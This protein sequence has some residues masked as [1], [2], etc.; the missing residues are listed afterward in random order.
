[1]PPRSTSPS[2][3]EQ[4]LTKLLAR[5]SQEQL[6]EIAKN[7]QDLTAAKDNLGP[8]T[9]EELWWT[10]KE[11][12]GVELG[13]VAV[14][15]G[16][17]SQLDL[18]WEV[19]S[20]V[21]TRVLWVLSRGSGKTFLMA[22]TDECQ[23]E[24]YPGFEAFTIG[25]GKSQGERKYD[26]ILPYVIE[27]GVIGGKEFDHVARSILTKTE[28]LNGSKMEISL[29]GEPENANGP[30]VPRLHRDEIELMKE[31]TR[32]QA[33]NIPA[34][35]LSRDGRY[36]PAQIIDTSTMKYAGGYVDLQM[37]AYNEAKIKGVRPR[38][39]VRI[40]CI[41]EAAHEVACCRAA[42]DDARRARLA[43]LGRDPAEL[44]EC[45]EVISGVMPTEDAD[46]EPED[47]TLEKVCQ[48]RLFRSRGHK[49]YAD[50]ITLFY[51][52]EPETWDAEQEC[53]QPAREGAYIRSYSQLRH[54]VRG[55][56]PDPENGP[57][58][59]S[60]D[61][62]GS[63]A[64]SHGWYQGLVRDVRCA[65]FK[66]G[67]IKTLHA[68]SVVRFAE[69]YK[70]QIG[71]VELGQMVIDREREWMLRWPGWQVHERYCD[72]ANRS[73]ILNWRD[74]C[75]LVAFSRVQKDFKQEVKMVRSR[76]GGRRFYVDIREC[77][78][79]DK[80]IRA[81]HQENGHEVHDWSTHPTAE[82]RYFE[83][84]YQVH[85]RKVKRGA[86]ALDVDNQPSTAED[87]DQ[88]QAER[89]D[90]LAGRVVVVNDSRRPAPEVYDVGGA[91]DSPLTTERA[92]DRVLSDYGRPSRRD[93]GI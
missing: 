1:M 70:D 9:K 48:G 73:G 81:W 72:V 21:V 53:S 82:L 12:Y 55:Y 40:S 66:T 64:H 74:Q 47:R 8:Q 54:G 51:E 86:R 25:P 59:T 2:L 89:H 39:E 92:G 14:C 16:H 7:L 87:D 68:G 34:G 27:G 32:K 90:E 41:Y 19:Y 49:E 24:F 75:G 10:F 65:S 67:L 30:R 58:Y 17:T 61:W 84:N 85:E 6:V 50:I 15:E 33:G 45:D 18:V 42:P 26:H 80:A 3:D 52:N 83:S 43:E 69:I 44:C 93:W 13:R 22:L 62:G 77:P 56:E 11:R 78:M 60:T 91:E 38:Q 23:S 71:D 29:G 57:L 31:K 88:R 76:A 4:T 35:R 46:E 79:F 37:E 5:F 63:D 20:F 28:Y 36:M